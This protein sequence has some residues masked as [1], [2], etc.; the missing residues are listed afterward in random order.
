MIENFKNQIKNKKQSTIVY[1]GGS[2]TEGAGASA[3]EFSWQGRIHKWIQEAF[4]GCT[5][6]GYNAGIGGTNSEFGVFRLKEH[7]LSYHPDLVFVEFAVNDYKRP[8]ENIL[9]SIEGIIR[10]LKKKNPDIT[11]IFIYTATQK[12]EEECYEKGMLP[13][14]V[15]AHET[16]AAYYG[17]PSF[18]AG[19]R[20]FQKIK[21]Q[22]INPAELLPDLVHPNDQGHEIYFQEIKGF[23]KRLWESEE[24]QNYI[25]KEL[26]GTGEYEDCGMVPAKKADLKEFYIVNTPLCGRYPSYIESNRPGAELVF[27]FYGTG[28]G[29]LWMIAGDSGRI[30]WRVDQGQWHEDSSWDTYALRFDR[31]NHK[32][33][34]RNLE[35]G[36]HKVQIR[37]S[38]KSDLQSTG[39]FIRLGAFLTIS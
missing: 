27:T 7:V 33:L 26:L 9:N 15:E 6:T 8:K 11:I 14:S 19:K 34:T 3:Q 39:R 29:V 36:E 35:P 5:I 38:E 10:Q 24:E 1:L 31:A 18:N 23:L 2:I 28:I 13:G 30:Q 4:L 21:H 32:M 17:I 22:N 25:E 16:L 20:L 37:I 12:M